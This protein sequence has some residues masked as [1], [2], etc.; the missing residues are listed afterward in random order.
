M[1]F[2]SYRI[3]VEFKV[4]IS[5]GKVARLIAVGLVVSL[6]DKKIGYF[7]SVTELSLIVVQKLFL[8]GLISGFYRKGHL[9]PFLGP[10]RSSVTFLSNIFLNKVTFDS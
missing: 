9:G 2:L 6:R 3:V 4:L 5:V 10:K 1:W 7:D 8:I